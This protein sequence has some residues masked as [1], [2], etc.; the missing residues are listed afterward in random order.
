MASTPIRVLVA[1]DFAPFRRFVATLQQEQPELQIVGEVTDGL[2]AVQ[3]AQELQPDLILLDLALPTL[4]GFEAARRIRTVAPKSRILCVSQEASADIVR[5][6]I[7]AGARGYVVKADAGS[8]LL[9]AIDAVLR[10]ER[11][12]GGRFGKDVLAHG[13]DL[14]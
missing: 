13:S 5:A 3:K 9:I 7:C 6:A 14:N 8:E 1:D 2:D 11:F 4:N 10:G 12:I